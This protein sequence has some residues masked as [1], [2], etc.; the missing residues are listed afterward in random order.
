MT[1]KNFSLKRFLKLDIRWKL[2]I[3]GKKLEFTFYPNFFSFNGFKSIYSYF[4]FNLIFFEKVLKKK[5]IN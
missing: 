3:I 5:I 2:R 4:V 1:I